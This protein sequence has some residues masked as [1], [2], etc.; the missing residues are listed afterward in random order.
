MIE[1]PSLLSHCWS[2]LV[3][4]WENSRR[5]SPQSSLQRDDEEDEWARDVETSEAPRFAWDDPKMK[6]FLDA[7][8]YVVVRDALTAP[9]IEHAENLLWQYLGDEAGWSRSRP[10]TWTDES[11]RTVGKDVLGIVNR[12]G[13]G[14]TDLAWFVRTRTAVYSAFCQLWSTDQ[15]LTSFDGFNIFR[16]WH[17]HNF[18]KTAGNWLHVDQGP[19]KIGRHGVQGFVSLYDQD[20]TTGGLVVIPQ[21]HLRHEEV[22]SYATSDSDF[23]PCN[24]ASSVIQ[25]KKRLVSCKAGDLVLWDSRCVHCNTPALCAP[26]APGSRLLRVCVYVCMTPRAWASPQTL[27]DRRRAYEIR[28]STSHWPHTNCMG[29]GWS[30]PG[31][32]S[33]DE[34]P[35]ERKQLI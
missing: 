2:F 33:Y 17:K 6:D 15:L 22:L 26:T 4:L 11:F 21:S 12:R 14:Q 7:Q 19:T 30:R 31:P 29:F 27:S 23:V 25:M 20:A 5:S 10:S 28:A 32:L 35:E 13:A 1:R 24:E 16:P 8:G 3:E 34:A 18:M 9:E